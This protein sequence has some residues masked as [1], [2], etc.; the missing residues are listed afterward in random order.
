M[1]PEWANTSGVLFQILLCSKRRASSLQPVLDHRVLNRH[2]RKYTFIMLR[3]LLA[4]RVFSKC[5]EAL[6]LLRNSIRIFPYIDEYLV[7]SSSREMVIKDSV[8]ILNHPISLRFRI[9]EAKSRLEPSQYT[10][11]LGLSI[12][13]LSYHVRLF[14]ERE[15]TFRHCF[16][17]FQLGKVV[18]FRLCLRLLDSWRLWYQWYI[19]VC[20]WWESFSGGWCRCVSVCR[21]KREGF[22]HN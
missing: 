2:L 21:V 1:G 4:L 19:W 22:F 17:L 15:S 8:T 11:Y 18:R 9:N 6:F 3:L 10:E 7:W 5:V 14:E 20:S 13:S 16:A 12:N